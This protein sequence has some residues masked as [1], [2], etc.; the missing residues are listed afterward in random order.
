MKALPAEVK[1]ALIQT[2]QYEYQDEHGNHRMIDLKQPDAVYM[3]AGTRNVAEIF[4]WQVHVGDGD[5]IALQN[6]ITNAV[7]SNERSV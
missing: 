7:R 4:E 3:L 6:T 5:A 2:R 1:Q